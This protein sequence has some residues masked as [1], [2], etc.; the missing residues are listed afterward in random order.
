MQV[1]TV[2]KAGDRVKAFRGATFALSFRDHQHVLSP[3]P[4]PTTGSY[5]DGYRTFEPK[6][7]A[8]VICNSLLANSLVLGSGS[9][10]WG[11]SRPELRATILETSVQFT[12]RGQSKTLVP[13]RQDPADPDGVNSQRA[14]VWLPGSIRIADGSI[15]LRRDEVMPGLVIVKRRQPV[16]VVLTAKVQSPS[17]LWFEQEVDHF[18]F[19]FDG[20][21]VL[22]GDG[23]YGFGPTT[24][25]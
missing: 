12:D 14:L 3:L 16:R 13:P 1:F 17:G 25:P 15:D 5:R 11:F 9:S 18:T 24:L 20:K 7:S 10:A 8:V 21:Y 22:P 23:S 19:E 6:E 4:E 2:I